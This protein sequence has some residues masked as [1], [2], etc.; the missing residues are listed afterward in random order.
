MTSRIIPAFKILWDS[1]DWRSNLNLKPQVE[2]AG[3]RT[4]NA[5]LQTNFSRQGPYRLKSDFLSIK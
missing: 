3:F 5:L 4:M 2:F 1:G